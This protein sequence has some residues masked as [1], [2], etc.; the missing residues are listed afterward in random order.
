MDSDEINSITDTVEAQQVVDILKSVYYDVVYRANLPE[1]YTIIGLEASGDNDKPVLMTVPTTVN[2]IE[3]VKYDK[4][5]ESADPIK[6]EEVTFMGLE[7]FLEFTYGFDT[8]ETNVD[9]FT[10]TLNGNDFTFFYKT[11]VAPTYYTTFDDYTL[12]F[13][14]YDSSL[15]TTLQKS[16]SMCLARLIPSFT[17]SDTFTP[18][19]DAEQF[20]LLLNEAKSLA[21]AELRQSAHGIADR[22]SRRAWTHIQKNKNSSEVISDFNKLP[23][24]GRK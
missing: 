4:R 22:N 23:N 11:D 9:T 1:H 20:T 2:K 10:H 13:D 14:S 8:E 6:M 3:W 16:K 18:D 7:D 24:F 15:D 5:E 21:W 17:K 19:L 12:I